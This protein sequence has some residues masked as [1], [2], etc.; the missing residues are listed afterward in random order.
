M[1]GL[2]SLGS[3]GKCTLEGVK[4]PQMID[5]PL[6]LSASQYGLLEKELQKSQKNMMMPKDPLYLSR[7]LRVGQ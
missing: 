5:I 4:H 2:E 6:S 1:L 3:S 7:N